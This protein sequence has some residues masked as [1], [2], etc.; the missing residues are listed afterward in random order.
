MKFCIIRIIALFPLF[1]TPPVFVHSQSA[2]TQKQFIK[3]YEEYH[4]EGMPYRLMKPNDSAEQKN[5]PLVLSL[6]GGSGR[7]T[8]NIRNLATESEILATKE[9]RIKYPCFVLAPQSP[10][11]SNWS[12]P[13]V[14]RPRMSE[15]LLATFPIA[16]QNR[17]VRQYLEA[18]KAMAPKKEV[19]N[20][21][22]KMDKVMRLV[23]KLSDELPIDKD[24]IYV[25]GQSMGGAGAWNAI[26]EYPKFF[27]GAITSASML[28]PWMDPRKF[29]EVPVWLFHGKG[30]ET[31]DYQCG[32]DAFER[33]QNVGANLKFTTLG[34]EPHG[35]KTRTIAFSNA[36]DNPA[37]GYLTQFASD[38][39]DRD[40]KVWDWLFKQKRN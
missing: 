14:R 20:G 4:F 33:A 19:P 11:N 9:N 1:A 34:N 31:V 28:L 23:E 24:R 12:F 15:E 39:C 38:K 26:H 18:D 8:D 32:V 6:H 13:N 29:K 35:G 7:G 10:R 16:Y 3:L 25:V 5:F 22:G 40:P 17:F 30:D 21:I 37:K 36:G 2:Q 27:A